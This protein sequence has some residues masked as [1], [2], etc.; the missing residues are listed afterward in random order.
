MNINVDIGAA[1]GRS[2]IARC[3]WAN[4]SANWCRS[5]EYFIRFHASK[6]THVQRWQVRYF[7]Y[8]NSWCDVYILTVVISMFLFMRYNRHL[9]TVSSHN[10][11]I[12]LH[13]TAINGTVESYI[14]SYCLI[15]KT[16]LR[17]IPCNWS[18]RIYGAVLLFLWPALCFN[19]FRVSAGRSC[20]TLLGT[21]LSTCVKNSV[22]ELMLISHSI[23]ICWCWIQ[24]CISELSSI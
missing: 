24:Q 10:C 4:L 15:K 22:V 17:V 18:I 5:Q 20:A 7:I 11:H 13:Y 12:V 21:D 16:L 8:S 6:T 19:S 1:I 3:V 2:A 9:F 14:K 23:V